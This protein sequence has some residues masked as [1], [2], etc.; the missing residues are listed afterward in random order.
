MK[1]LKHML[2]SIGNT[3]T[4]KL[5]T[6]SK[7][8]GENVSLYAKLEY[9]NPTGSV[10]DRAALGL[11]KDARTSSLAGIKT[12][13]IDA[14]FGNMG[15]SI[16]YV[17]HL[18][19]H[20]CIIVSPETMSDY[21]KK[22][23][24]AMGAKLILTDRRLGIQGAIKKAEE[25]WRDTEGS[26][27]LRQFSNDAAPE[28]CRTTLGPE[29]YETFGANLGTLICGVGSGSTITGTA[30]YLKKWLPDLH[31]VAVEPSESAVL[32]GKYAGP[33]GIDGIGLGFVPDNY[34]P[35][36]VDEI[37]PV[38]TGDAEAA[39]KAAFK[40]DGISCGI[41]SGAVLCAAI[42]YANKNK[43]DK[44]IALIFADGA[45]R[46]FSRKNF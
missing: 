7:Q 17:A 15:P 36:I 37:I 20:S 1:P 22:Q 4:V 32:S 23:T 33:H 3:P 30:E 27:M 21:N 9:Y 38:C 14:V 16:A 31:V 40:A 5:N 41:S 24:V 19:G 28:A 29:L 25:V 46:Y 39:A 35:Y 44:D 12:I 43:T 8:L 13:L 2:Y 11:I 6:V 45:A 34:N 18:L 10:T 26:Y 42:Q